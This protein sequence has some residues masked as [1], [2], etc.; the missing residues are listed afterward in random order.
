MVGGKRG[1]IRA[2]IDGCR[3]MAAPVR[4]CLHAMDTVQKLK[5]RLHKL[6]FYLSSTLE[7]AIPDRWWRRRGAKLIERLEALPEAS[8]QRILERVDYYN[9]LDAPFSPA[10]KSEK[11]GDFS[12]RGHSAAYFM[13]FKRYI[14][15]FPPQA[16]VNYLFGD[17]VKVPPEPAFLKSRPIRDDKSNANSVLLKLNQV[18]HYYAVRDTIPYQEKEPLA[19]WRGKAH[20]AH[21]Q[22]FLDRYL[23]HPRCNVGDVR[24]QS[25]GQPINRPFMSIE[26]QLR[27]RYVVSIEGHDVATNLKWIMASNSLCVM[28]RPRYETWFMEGALQPGV[29]YVPLKDDHSDLEEQMNYYDEHPEEAR[30]I[31]ENANQYVGQ[32]R[33]SVMEE[34]IGFLVIDRFLRLSGQPS[35]K[36]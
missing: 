14:R 11:I 10:E 20:Q 24:K 34:L 9:R 30:R 33:D 31:I 7:L 8:R 13:D 25:V 12:L 21:R 19:V 15:H 17:I 1:G 3:I 36:S 32:F 27:Y 5:K 35:L 22:E 4:I 2:G 28:R 6:G 29:H 18:R 26:E 16:R 23:D